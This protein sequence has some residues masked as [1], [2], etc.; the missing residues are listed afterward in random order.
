MF[1]VDECTQGDCAIRVCSLGTFQLLSSCMHTIE[2]TFSP[3]ARTES[4]KVHRFILLDEVFDRSVTT[5]FMHDCQVPVLYASTHSFPTLAALGTIQS[6]LPVLFVSSE[7]L[8][9]SSIRY[10]LCA[11]TCTDQ[12][13]ITSRGLAHDR[14]PDMPCHI[15]VKNLRNDAVDRVA[16]LIRRRQR[17]NLTIWGHF[18]H[19]ESLV[20]GKVGFFARPIRSS[21]LD[22]SLCSLALSI[23][24]ISLSVCP[25][26]SLCSVHCCIRPHTRSGRLPHTQSPSPIY[27]YG[28]IYTHTYIHTRKTC[29]R[30]LYAKL[31]GTTASSALLLRM[32][33][34]E[35]VPQVLP[36]ASALHVD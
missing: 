15:D 16:Q 20:C 14:F 22:R 11:G 10:L 36:L 32:G 34:H 26:G 27:I 19:E 23:C 8:K 12:L 9:H 13:K 31:S 24:G 5:V 17:E 6:L 33:G 2:V 21:T 4:D 3:G 30:T 29:T 7:S 35:N 1:Y 18:R 25:S 28:Y